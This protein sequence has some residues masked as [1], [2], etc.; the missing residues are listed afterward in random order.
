[1][2]GWMG[3][4]VGWVMVDWLD[5]GYVERMEW[6]RTHTA[7]PVPL[8]PKKYNTTVHSIDNAIGGTK[9]QTR[10]SETVPPGRSRTVVEWVGGMTEEDSQLKLRLKYL[11]V[12]KKRCHSQP[13]FGVSNVERSHQT[14]LETVIAE[15][16][17]CQQVSNHT[18]STFYCHNV[19]GTAKQGIDVH[20]YLYW[21]ICIVFA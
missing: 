21:F 1:M 3:G 6:T 2:I 9:F 8:L 5:D 20:P 10:L 17:E 18:T 19:Y 4:V 11:T 16:G 14:S 15:T 12:V 13:D 7:L